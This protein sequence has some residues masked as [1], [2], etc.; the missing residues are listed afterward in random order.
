MLAQRLSRLLLVSASASTRTTGS[1]PDGRTS[2]RPSPP[3][4]CVDLVD[5]G[6]AAACGSVLAARTRTFSFTC[7]IARHHGRRLG[8][9]AAL[10]RRAEQQRG[11][12]AVAGDVVAQADDVAGLLAAEHAALALQRLEHVA[13]AD[14]GRDDADRRAPPSAGGSRGSSSSSPR[15]GRRRGAARGSRRSG[16]R[17]RVSPFAST[18]S[19]R[20]PSPSNAMPRSS[21]PL[22]TCACSAREVGRAAADVDVRRRPAR[23]RSPSTSAPSSLER[24]RRD[25]RVGAV[26]AV[27]GD[28]QAG[29]V[30]AEALEH[31]LEIAVGRDVDAVD[32][33]RR[34]GAGASSSASI[35]SSAAS[36]S[37]L[38]VAVEELDA[39]VLG[40][41]VRRGDDDAEVEREQRDRRRRQR[42]P[43]G[44]RCRPPTRRRART[45]PRAPRPEPRVSRPTKTRP[46]PDQSAD[47]LPSRST[48]SGVRNSPTMPRTPSVPK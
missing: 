41:V 45:P 16:R 25:A 27:D 14:V 37:L 6:R 46:R 18:A 29:E 13:V 32:L 24:L 4:S 48:S 33:R 44:P 40:R 2:T 20:S 10:E 34:R 15:P 3:S 39:V 35:S 30:G 38:P 9:R 11:R 8:Q 36:V 1:V 7:G 5:L 12:E 21:P 43:R 23:C 19:M 22:A 17:R 26:R 31:V 28:A 42:R 47:A